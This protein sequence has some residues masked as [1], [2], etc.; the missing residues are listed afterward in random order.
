MGRFLYG[1]KTATARADECVE[2]FNQGAHTKGSSVAQVIQLSPP[3]VSNRDASALYVDTP[4]RNITPGFY[5]QSRRS[6]TAGQNHSYACTR[7]R[8]RLLMHVC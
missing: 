1:V 4:P 7:M 6:F 2:V 3:A 5:A 8:A